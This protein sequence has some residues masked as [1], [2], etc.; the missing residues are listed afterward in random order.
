MAEK[1]L[2]PRGRKGGKSMMGNT[3]VGMT[4]CVHL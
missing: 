2:K 1:R 4:N 3:V